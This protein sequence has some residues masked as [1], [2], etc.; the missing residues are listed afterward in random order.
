MSDDVRVWTGEVVLPTYLPAAPEVH[1]MFL[2]KRVYQGSSG[3]V[4]PLP[5]TDRIAEEPV[6]RRWRAIEVENAFLKVLILPEL[7]GRIHAVQDKTNGYDLVY[8]QP[9]IKP[10]LVGLAGPWISGGIEFNWPQHHRPATFLPV[11]VALEEHPDGSRTVWLG[12]HDP[13]TRMKG[14]HGVCLHPDRAVLELKVR[15]VNRT[16]LTRTFLWWANVAT[17][18]H[19]GYQSFFP[20]DMT[21]VA[22]HA[23]RATSRFPL[24]EGVYYGVDYGARGREGVPVEDRPTRYVPWHDGT[25]RSAGSA[26]VGGRPGSHWAPECR[27]NDLSWYANIPTP[28]SY[29]CLGTREDFFGGYDHCAEAGLLHVADHHLAPGKKQWTW[30]NHAFGHAWDRNLTVATPEGEFPPYIELMAG[31]YTDNQPDFSHLRPGEVKTWRQFWYPLQRIGPPCHANLDVA[32]SFL[33]RG[34]QARIGVNVTRRFPGARIRLTAGGRVRQWPADLVPGEPWLREVSWSLGPL[35]SSAWN[36]EVDDGEGR[37]RLRYESRPGSGGSAPAPAP[38]PATE[39]PAPRDI[40]S[41]DRLYLT[42]RHLEQYRHATR[43]PT[44]YWREALRRDPGDARCNLAL[45]RWHLERG[46]F[47]A[48]EA[49]CGRAVA[50]WTERNPNPEDGAAHYHLGVCRR[51]LGRDAEA[52]E[53]LH[54]AAWDP[55]WAGAALHALAEM[56]AAQARWTEALALLERALAVQADHPRAELLLAAVLRRVGRGGE[57][58]ARLRRRLETDPLDH[59]ARHRLGWPLECDL[60]VRLDLALDDARAGLL[61]EALDV[62]EI[63]PAPVRDL[64]DQNLGTAPLVHYTRA[65]LHHRRGDRRACRASLR[66]AAAAPP[67]Y[68]FPARLEEIGIL[69]FARQSNPRDARAPYYLGNLFY[70]RRRHPEAIRLWEESAAKDP[71]FAGVW[72]NLGIAYFNIARQPA[73]AR[74]AYDTAC[75]CAP[76]DARLLFERDQLWKRLGISPVRRLKALRAREDLV[77]RRDDLTLEL[78]ALLHQ[79]GRPAKALE[80]LESRRFQPWEGGEGLVLAQYVRTRLAL[81]RAALSRGDAGRAEDAFRG[82]LH[83]PETLGE[84]RH[85]LANDSDVRYWLGCALAALGRDAEAREQW[86]RAASARGDFQDMSVREYSELTYYSAL[87]LERLGQRAAARRLLGDVRR[88]A[89]RLRKAR[90]TI[91]YFATSLP[92]MLLFDDDLQARQ[93]T[94]ARLLEAQAHL[95]LGRRALARQQLRAVLRRDPNHPLAADLLRSTLDGTNPP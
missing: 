46:E 3:R 29:M 55:G 49:C 48:A 54:K 31:V 91:D 15:V 62:L 82:A 87:A 23:R 65:W 67:D 41:S 34:R 13:M 9:V 39:P 70:D 78:C 25:G 85:P 84:A 26:G 75:R 72:R 14:M 94:T 11:D 51:W 73:R 79:S 6:E 81:G 59:A 63:G 38:A 17:R 20:P 7:G 2:E 86:R 40:A 33:V 24:A 61:T 18:V 93:E 1:P 92:N 66:R 45:G 77:G 64:P 12:D 19:E 50:R 53:A 37:Q 68:C 8:R 10:A 44:L 42:G 88:Y 47:A 74:R 32:V 43:C 95:G 76:D 56:E 71:G 35:A 28:C 22:D 89:Q 58:E 30:G 90:A 52:A 27:P 21:W 60:Q 80:R 57:A 5:F 83:P 36:L 69:E 16:D 4:Y